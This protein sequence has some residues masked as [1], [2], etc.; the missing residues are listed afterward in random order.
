MSANDALRGVAIGVITNDLADIIDSG[1]S[2]PKADGGQGVVDGGV[3][4]GH[5]HFLSLF[6][7]DY[8]Q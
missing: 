1:C 2:G 5:V 6:K 4:I 7:F 3:G 8:L